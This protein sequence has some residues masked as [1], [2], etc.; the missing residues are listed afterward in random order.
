MLLDT[1]LLLSATY[2][3]YGLLTNLTLIL[4]VGIAEGI[5]FVFQQ[6]VAL[7]LLADAAPEDARGQAQG[8]AGAVGAVGGAA[9]AFAALPLYHATHLLPFLLAALLTA[10]GSAAAAAGAAA[11]TRQRRPHAVAASAPVAAR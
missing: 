11:L 5:V 4:L 9:S 6:P 1:G 3:A 10:L 2:V 7:G 8:I